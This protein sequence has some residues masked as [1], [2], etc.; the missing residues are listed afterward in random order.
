MDKIYDVIIIGG[1]PA[2]YTAALYACRAGFS[3]LLIEKFSAGG[4]M[5]ET[6]A[7]DNYPGFPDGIDGFTLGY[8]MQ[9]GAERF[10]CETMQTE[11][12]ATCLS[13]DIKEVGTADGTFYGKAV[14]IAT[15]ATHKHL[16]LPEED[17]LIGK[18]VGYCA[19][20]DGTFYRGKTVMVIGGGNS[21]TGDAAYL[22][23]ICE[24]VIIVHRRD[25]LR[26]EK[27]YADLL[28]KAKN[29]EFMWNSVLDKI[30]ADGK[31]SGAIIKN[32]KD[33]TFTEV[34]TDGIFISIGRIPNTSLFQ[35]E[36]SLDGNGYIIADESTLTSIPGVFAAGDVRTKPFRQIVTATSDGACAAHA[37][38]EYLMNK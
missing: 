34:K 31:V 35:N 23:N 21:A 2:G 33:N 12:I 4:Q 13:K 32:V 27:Y 19:T 20:C 26:A 5:T 8:N 14:I 36:L 38:E 7:I 30:L 24:K 37:L 16:G 1:G 10:G 9:K 18:G 22:S 29:I 11:V 15:G 6:N 28:K 25:T 17:S 3:T